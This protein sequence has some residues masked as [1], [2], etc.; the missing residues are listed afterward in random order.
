M[1][2]FIIS[3]FITVAIFFIFFTQ[4]SLKDLYYILKRIDPLWALL[5]TGF[6]ILS[7]FFRALRFKWL[8]Y[9]R[10]I[11]IYE[12]FKISVLYN[13]SIMIL[14]SKFGELSFPYFLKR[15]SGRSITEG[16]ASLITSR[17]YD[18]SILIIIFLL[19]SISNQSYFKTSSLSKFLILIVSIFIVI[20]IIILFVYMGKILHGISTLLR[21]LSQKSIFRNWRSWQWIKKKLNEF[22]EDFYATKAKKTSLQVL[23]STLISWIMIFLAF[24]SFLMGFGVRLSILNVIFSSTF[25]IIA[26]AIPIGVI[27]NWG[28]LE[29]GWTVGFLINGLSKQ[30]AITSGF[31]VHILIFIVCFMMATIFRFNLKR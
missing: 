7:T 26:S 4:I 16:L 28:T 30:D 24:Y 25:A 22:A 21:I 2:Q 19:A 8:I 13:L 12:L 20:I 3:A 9:T 29:V 27:G 31:A 10:E 1:K 17:I 6:Y 23:S 15:I 11:P 5:G 14:P 18:F